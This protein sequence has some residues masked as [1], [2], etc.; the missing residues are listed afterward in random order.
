M[1]ELVRYDAACRAVAEAKTVDEAKSIRDHAEA[2]RVYARQAKNKDLEVDAAEIRMRAERRLGEL[3]RGQR[4]TVGLNKGA[5]AGGKK[6]APRGSLVEPRDQSPT[7]AAAG[8]DRKLSARAQRVAAIP[9]AEFE[10]IVGDWRSRIVIENERVTTN[11]LRAADKAKIRAQTS[12]CLRDSGCTVNDLHEL[13]EGGN[14]FGCIYADPPWLY[15]NQ[16]TRAATSNHY[17]GMTVDELCDL[18]IRRLAAED[19]HLHLWTTNGFLFECRRIFD[20]WGFEFRSS[21]IWVKPQM[22]IGNYWRNS[23]EILLTAIRGNA[24]QFNDK[25]L[26]SWIECDRGRHSA[27]PEEIRH[28]IARASDGPFLELFGRSPVK[29]WSVWGNEVAPTALTQAAE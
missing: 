23:H 11:I 17:K 14:H 7:L 2:M 10:A 9:A 16:G 19:A 6:D 15:D 22:G 13:I 29:G 8:I 25:S 3:L 18:P 26:K 5:A 28:L 24:K 1:T 20:A 27:K 4:E 21:F 12:V